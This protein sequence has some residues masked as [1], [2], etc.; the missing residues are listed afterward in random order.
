MT[1]IEPNPNRFLQKY[2]DKLLENILIRF[3]FKSSLYATSIANHHIY[4]YKGV[5]QLPPLVILHGGGDSAGSYLPL[6]LKLRKHFKEVI[7]VEAPGHGLSGEP[8]MPY[9]F[10][11]HYQTTIETL[12]HF[13]SSKEPA[14]I[15][16]HSLGGMTAFRYAHHSPERIRK[17]FLLSSMGAPMSQAALDDLYAA[18]RVTTLKEAEVFARRMLHEVPFLKLGFVKRLVFAQMKRQAIQSLVEATTTKEGVPGEWLQQIQV[19]VMLIYG[20]S[21]RIATPNSVAFF[22]QNLPNVIIKEP[23]NIG[24]CPHIENPKYVLSQLL[25]FSK[26]DD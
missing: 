24:H 6:L 4:Q 13:V 2:P 8:H 17:L 5:G 9:T 11:D 26:G 22:S 19:P 20:K 18:F 14:I 21:D 7:A 1:V 3:D 23:A 25:E 10:A 12:D 16:G 15:M